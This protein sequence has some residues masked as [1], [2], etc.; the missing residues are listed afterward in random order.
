MKSCKM[1][2]IV[3]GDRFY[4]KASHL[5]WGMEGSHLHRQGE[6]RHAMHPHEG[7]VHQRKI[8]SKSVHR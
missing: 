7:N 5:V 4:V 6:P 1:Q 2:Y 8:P 3:A